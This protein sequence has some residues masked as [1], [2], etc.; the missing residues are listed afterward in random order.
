MSQ[1]HV[2]KLAKLEAEI[3]K[4]EEILNKRTDDLANAAKDGKPTDILAALKEAMLSAERELAAL[5]KKELKMEMRGT[6]SNILIVVNEEK[7]A[8]SQQCG[9]AFENSFR[10]SFINAFFNKGKALVVSA[11]YFSPDKA[12]RKYTNKTDHDLLEQCRA[13]LKSLN[14]D[15]KQ[16]RFEDI[17]MDCVLRCYNDAKLTKEFAEPALILLPSKELIVTPPQLFERKISDNSIDEGYSLKP[18]RYIVVEI[19]S[20]SD[21]LEQKLVQL[22]KDLLFLL[23]RNEK[24]MGA[25]TTIES[26]IS[27]AVLVIPYAPST[28]SEMDALIHKTILEKKKIH[29]LL[30]RLYGLG[31]FARYFTPVG[32]K[33]VMTEMSAH[34]ADNA[35]SSQLSLEIKSLRMKT[36]RVDMLTK[37]LIAAR[38]LSS[39]PEMVQT[40][41]RLEKELARII[42]E[43]NPPENDETD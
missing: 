20:N 39:V 10:L 27:Y 7:A 9:R 34:I 32:S 16:L 6:Y 42:I 26:I 40:A 35:S 18:N 5:R 12:C 13:A 3:D 11:E 37:E 1:I 23:L 33:A 31:R 41:A 24:E 29:P 2:D 19:T 14:W 8:T 38:L 25:L 28:E 17:Q 21:N 15:E 43:D 4:A 36:E 30:F 22:E